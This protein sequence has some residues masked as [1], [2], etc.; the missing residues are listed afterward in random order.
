MRI[1]LNW[2]KELLPALD[3]TAQA[4]GDRLTEAGLELEGIARF[5]AGLEAIRVAEVRAIEPHPS[6]DKLRLVTVS[7]GD[8]E[9]TVVCG[10]SN[11]PAPGGLVALAENGSYLPAKDLTLV[12]RDIGGV[13]SHGMLCSE[14]ELGLTEES[15]GILILPSGTE[16]GAP[17]PQALPSCQ[18]WILEFGI[19]PNRP[20]ALGH[21][22]VAREVA[23]LYG[24]E[25]Q[26]EALEPEAPSDELT[27]RVSVDNQATDRCPHY[28]TSLILGVKV[29]PSPLPVR[30]RLEALGVRSISNV[31]DVTNLVLLE[32]GHPLHAF[33]L[34]LLE[35][36]R[37]V[38]RRAAEGEPL[39]TLDGAERQLTADDLVI[40]DAQR[41]VALAGVMGGENTEIRT[42]TQ[43][44][45]LEC[46]YFTPHGVR[47]SSRRH[48]LST[49]ASYRFERGV[50]FSQV[51]LV[52]TR[53]A[54][55]LTELA[56]GSVVPGQ[57]H[58][59]GESPELPEITLRH[60]RLEALLG[61]P[62]P[63]DEALTLLTRL[64]FQLVHHE[65]EQ[66]R[67]RGAA[68]RPDVTRE[69]D[70]IEEVARV[71]GL[72]RI[73][74]ELPAITP[75]PPRPRGLT[76]EFSHHAA[77]LGLSEAVTY[78]FVAPRDLSALS[79][80]LPI[81]SLLNPLSEERSVLRT[82]L[83]PGLLE[84]LGRARRR[85]EQTVR[86]F[87]VGPRFLPSAKGYAGS[88]AQP[89]LI[90][91]APLP[92]E[93]PSFAALL[94]GPR[95]SYLTG[96][97]ERHDVYDLKGLA[98][99]LIQRT[100]RREVEVVS[101]ADAPGAAHL[102]P[103]G[104]GAL[105]LGDTQVGTLGPLHPDVLDAYDLGAEALVLELDL[106]ALEALG[107]QAPHYQPVPKL[108]AVTRDVALVVAD[109]TPAGDVTRLIREA[110]GELCESV[111]LFDSFTGGDVPAGHRS[112]AFRVVYRDP[113]AR[114]D[115]AAAKT[116][117]DK[118]VDEAHARAVSRAGEAVGATLRA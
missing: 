35:G 57:L 116:L 94:A 77:A 55:Q 19:T 90:S 70:L 108:P 102:H 99:E 62:V 118:Q 44:V 73:P 5:G 65:A 72:D 28:G 39:R 97:P 100:L 38:I 61:C 42:E 32:Y 115:P 8:R 69:A 96:K 103:R 4:L 75:A 117:T 81:V 27:A 112:L 83:L 93:R 17:L 14:E 80:P 105:L 110:A 10:A 64:G 47:R 87:T 23:A 60:A 33:D 25:W 114:T 46:A 36:P 21:R 52:L 109:R 113:K 82:S 101:A 37:V 15:E 106:S 88:P 104:A 50:D 66:A 84:A 63:F 95:P 22:G 78:A 107:E 3:T 11:V 68:H 16:V 29:A 76:R 48:G 2:L 18:D 74:A 79:A 111:E 56:G 86:L 85:G 91:D 20:D 67:L 40:C 43:D 53:A 12:P 58:A 31:V 34:A 6:R 98:V 41:P 26:P 89:R 92:E 1:S 24:L 59:R 13:T 45:L 54:Q 51:P 71:R 7:L 49:E 30:W 9:L